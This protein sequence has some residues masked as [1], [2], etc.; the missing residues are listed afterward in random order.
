MHIKTIK[1]KWERA[2]DHEISLED[3]DDWR[4]KANKEN[5]LIK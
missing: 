1:S 5:D 4:Q 3:V 2:T